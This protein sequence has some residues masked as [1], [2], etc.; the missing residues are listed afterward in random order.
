MFSEYI[1]NN[2]CPKLQETVQGGKL[3]WGKNDFSKESHEVPTFEKQD[4]KKRKTRVEG[5]LD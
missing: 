5:K 4:A 3:E 2:G 1:Y